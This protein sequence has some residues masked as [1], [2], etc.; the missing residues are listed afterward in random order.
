MNMGPDNFLK[1]CQFIVPGGG[2][3]SSGNR[4]IGAGFMKHADGV[5][6]TGL[7]RST[8]VDSGTGSN[9]STIAAGVG[10]QQIAFDVNLAAGPPAGTSA[11]DMVTSFVPGY[12][13][14]LIAL[15]FVTSIAGVGSSAT[16]TYNLEIG[17]TDVTLGTCV[18]TEASTSAV[19]EL[20]AGAA[21]TGA[22][23]GT[24][25]DAISIE[26]ADSGTAFTDGAGT[27]L[28][29]IQNMDVAD[30]FAALAASMSGVADETNGRVLKVPAAV[31]SVG[32]IVWA[33]PRDYDEGTDV[34]H[35]RVLASQLTVSTDNDVELDSE[36]YVKVPGSAL[37]SDANPTAPG[38][39]LSTT[40]QWIEFDLSGNSLTRDNVV[41]WELITNGANDTAGEEILI[42]AVEFVYASTL[43]SYD[44]T[45][46]TNVNLR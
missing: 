8:V 35:A 14:K 38:T 25:T 13:F 9:L 15:D 5:N 45:S 12:K 17:T 19:G 24:A 23:T 40:E 6:L 31:D 22:N 29:T 41:I 32:N 7:Q 36:L 28:V 11:G 27:F 2:T 3:D 20:T 16:Q 30:A 34:L 26:Q 42:H 37:A 39:V 18:V 21:I 1:A 10:V 4:K 33:V 46:S 43:V 44:R